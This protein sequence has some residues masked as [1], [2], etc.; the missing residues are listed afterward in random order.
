MVWIELPDEAWELIVGAL[1]IPGISLR[2]E[3]LAIV[4]AAASIDV[5]KPTRQTIR[6]IACDLSEAKDVLDWCEKSA[7]ILAHSKDFGPRHQAQLLRSTAAKI[8]KALRLS[9]GENA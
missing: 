7:E 5:T 3:T 2:P 4:E 6:S 8:R 9:A 1:R